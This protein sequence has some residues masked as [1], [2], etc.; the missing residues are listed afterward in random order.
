[1]RCCFSDEPESGKSP[2]NIE[3][4]ASSPSSTSATLSED[5]FALLIASEAEPVKRNKAILHVLFYARVPA[6][7]IL[8]FCVFFVK[9]FKQYVDI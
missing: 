2:G 4:K 1:M 9:V 6:C 8:L 5:A 7:R 3:A